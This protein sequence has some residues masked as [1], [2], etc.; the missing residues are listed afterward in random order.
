MCQAAIPLLAK[1]REWIALNP[2]TPQSLITSILSAEHLMHAIVTIVQQEWSLDLVKA[3]GFT[4]NE[5]LNHTINLPANTSDSA[6][7][8]E[9]IECRFMQVNV[10]N[11][12]F[13][14]DSSASFIAAFASEK[15]LTWS[16]RAMRSIFAYTASTPNSVSVPVFA[17]PNRLNGAVLFCADILKHP[18]HI[19]ELS[20]EAVD[21][22]LVFLFEIWSVNA[23]SKHLGTLSTTLLVKFLITRFIQYE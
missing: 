15:A 8:E 23:S 4:R 1:M 10:L 6:S 18:F 22:D 14:L 12:L 9:R 11:A 19:R 13:K 7:E 16:V 17:L 5:I 20:V 21:C 2:F 3:T